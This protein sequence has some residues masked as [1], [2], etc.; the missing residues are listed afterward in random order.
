MGFVYVLNLDGTDYY[1]VGITGKE[2]V[3]DRIAAIQ[4]ST[5][6]EITVVDF[7][8]HDGY[9]EVEKLAHSLLAKYRIRG[10]WF[11]TT[12]AIVLEAYNTALS[13]V[14]IDY[15]L[16]DPVEVTFPIEDQ[17]TQT[18][19]EH[20]INSAITT[21][22]VTDEEKEQIRVW[23]EECI[24]R[25]IV[26]YRRRITRML[27]TARGGKQQSYNGSGPLYQVVSSCLNELEV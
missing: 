12:K 19:G 25:G 2:N 6:F 3:Q 15:A 9:M 22:P 13:M 26:Q 17:D 21:T 5:P 14:T 16:E 4:T 8:P 20:K 23:A 18:N 7:R 24:S 11:Y 10:E 27:Y 1:K